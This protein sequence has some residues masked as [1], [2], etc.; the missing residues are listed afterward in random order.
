MYD[1]ADW[2]LSEKRSDGDEQE[3][4]TI[5]GALRSGNGANPASSTVNVLIPFSGPG[6]WR[7]PMSHRTNIITILFAG[8]L[9]QNAANAQALIWDNEDGRYGT[10]ASHFSDP[11]QSLLDDMWFEQKVIVSDFSMLLVWN[12]GDVGHGERVDLI[13][14]SDVGGEPGMG[15]EPGEPFF[16]PGL[17]AYEEIPT[18]EL[19]GDR[20]VIDVRQ[21]VV[22]FVIEA[23]VFWL[24]MHIVGSDHGYQLMTHVIGQEGWVNYEDFGG[25]QPG[26]DVFGLEYGWIFKLFGFVPG[27]ATAA[28]M[29]GI[30]P[31]IHTDEPEGGLEEVRESDDERFILKAGN[32]VRLSRPQT[33]NVIFNTTLP[34]FAL[35]RLDV[36]IESQTT[37]LV[38]RQEL[39]IF[40]Y[41]ANR[42]LVLDNRP[43]TM[44]ADMI[45]T[46]ED[47]DDPGRFIRDSDGEAKLWVETYSPAFSALPHKLMIDELVFIATYAPLE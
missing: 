24:E 30:A 11:Y 29:R 43:L 13:L 34:G 25:L 46:I 32:G 22:P 35:E 45:V 41:E 28:Y 8:A 47:L 6:Q 26:S 20:T 40:D 33:A 16:W 23:D 1:S 17:L 38:V 4:S 19:L 37:K 12:S 2:P 18:E 14:W 9:C 27:E 31:L 44:G 7:P 3:M 36:R 15:G 10:A 5:I 39:S 42:W 21:Q